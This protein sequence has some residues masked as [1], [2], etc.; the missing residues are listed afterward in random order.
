MPVVSLSHS[1]T[2]QCDIDAAVR[3][4]TSL[5]PLGIDVNLP[6]DIRCDVTRDPADT[7]TPDLTIPAE[8][9]QGDGN[10]DLIAEEGNVSQE[11]PSDP[12]TRSLE[13][14]LQS[15]SI[16][17]MHSASVSQLELQRI[18]SEY[19]G[20]DRSWHGSYVRD[21]VRQMWAMDPACELSF[22]IP[23][24]LG[25][26]QK[27]LI[28]ALRQLAKLEIAPKRC[29]IVL[30]LNYPAFHRLTRDK[31]EP[32]H[33]QLSDIY[34]EAARAHHIPI[35]FFQQPLLENA[36]IGY[37]RKSL[38]DVV[39][40]RHLMRGD[41]GRDHIM[42]RTDADITYIDPRYAEYVLRTM[43]ENPLATSLHG[44]GSI[45]DE[46]A[47]LSMPALFLAHWISREAALF[48]FRCG[49]APLSGGP[50]VAMRASAYAR[51]RGFPT[52]CE[53]GEDIGIDKK[54]QQ[55]EL[56]RRR[57]I[58]YLP[59]TEASV[60]LGSE[61]STIETSARRALSA[62]SC[63]VPMLCQWI[64]DA[65]SFSLNGAAIR[66][67][68]DS[69]AP[70]RIEFL[71][72]VDSVAFIES[73]ERELAGILTVFAYN[74]PEVANAIVGRIFFPLLDSFVAVEPLHTSDLVTYRCK[75]QNP[76]QFRAALKEEAIDRF[77]SWERRAI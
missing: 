67:R 56:A 69:F 11:R 29:E 70:S 51:V 18:K 47:I 15:S 16:G 34:E 4:V 75:I 58:R 46:S 65:T 24:A 45:L 25:Q 14:A 9:A 10:S 40:F 12:W 61:E 66:Q 35:R 55:D 42:V 38:H 28:R 76:E 62:M 59:A 44:G 50:N 39:L 19:I 52:D 36:T 48:L 49:H 17:G 41:L 32:I 71:K 60:L 37:I 3:S 57:A 22:C 54:M 2:A 23:V 8:S 64:A 77:A 68:E 43:A 13:A 72:H 63:G 7:R 73:A 6:R 20:N 31:I 21:V 53:M 26:E 33:L 1:P 30:N 5:F 27:T 74:Q